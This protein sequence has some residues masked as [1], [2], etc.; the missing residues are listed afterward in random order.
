MVLNCPSFTVQRKAKNIAILKLT[1]PMTFR[2]KT[3]KMFASI[4]KFL[5]VSLENNKDNL[6]LPNEM[7]VYLILKD[8]REKVRKLKTMERIC[9]LTRS[10]RLLL[11]P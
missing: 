6:S 5:F 9:Q 1:S 3:A 10:C 8:V 4:A 11:S 2:K 7:L